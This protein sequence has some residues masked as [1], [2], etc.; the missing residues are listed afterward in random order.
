MTA[1][2]TVSE[3]FGA[4]PEQ[5]AL[6]CPA[7]ASAALT[8][9]HIHLPPNFGAIASVDDAIAKAKDENIVALCASNYYDHAIYRPFARAAAQAG[10]TPIFGIEALTMDEELRRQGVLVND[11]KNPGKFYL[12]GKGLAN[13]DAPDAAVLPIW[14]RIRNGDRRRIEEML[15][16]LNDLALL[17]QRGIRLDY[18]AICAEIAT[19]KRVPVETVFLQERHIAHAAQQA[20]FE[21]APLAERE[22]FLR[23]LYQAD[24]V[25]ETQDVVKAQNELRNYLFKQGKAAYADERYIS[26]DEAAALIRGLGGYVSYPILIDGIPTITPFEATPETLAEHLLARQIGAA[27]FI[28]TRNDLATLTR[29]V[30]SLRAQ[31]IVIGAGTEHNDAAWIPLRPACRKGVALSDELTAIFWEGA[32][33]AAAHQYLCAKGKTGFRF[34]ADAAGRNAQIQE[35]SAIGAAVVAAIAGQQG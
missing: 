7:S 22:D 18:Q 25:V 29:Y 24:G 15:A 3:M 13:F 2:T 27:E 33:V 31:G 26:P 16:R 23:Q 17:R 1:G 19:Q 8:N 30:K 21:R 32:R 4:L 9:L 14:E 10:I 34:F 5:N 20:I 12:C 35:F 6:P 28:P 11:P